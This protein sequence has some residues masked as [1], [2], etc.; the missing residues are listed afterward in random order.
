MSALLHGVASGLHCEKKKGLFRQWGGLASDQPSDALRL[1]FYT[2][3]HT[4]L[5]S[6]LLP[7][8]SFSRMRMKCAQNEKR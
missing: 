8:K 1:A 5:S 4:K 6:G 2:R 3:H 7:L